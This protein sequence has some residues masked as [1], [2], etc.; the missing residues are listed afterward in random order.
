MRALLSMWKDSRMVVMVALCATMYAAAIL[1]LR[2][3]PPF[4]SQL[5]A[6]ILPIPLSL[7]FGPAA[8][9]AM[10]IGATISDVVSGYLNAGS[11]FGLGSNF[12][13]GFLPCALW[14]RLRP[15][16][17]GSREATLRSWRHYALYIVIALT[18]AWAS[19]L[20]LAWPLDRFGIAPFRF[21]I[22]LVGVQDAVLGALSISLVLLLSK[23]ITALGLS[24]W[25]VMDD[26]DLDMPRRPLGIAG[27]WL[28]VLTALIA[29][30]LAV[31][32]PAHGISIVTTGAILVFLGAA[33]M[34]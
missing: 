3:P 2:L 18:T 28:V 8:A 27:A 15:L 31:W 4:S 11:I 1:S 19:A 32:S 25:D 7:M 29:W 5:V 33:A 9:W 21:I 22:T 12:M 23:R 17:D 30:P 16:S 6:I 14:S 20:V 13:L 26:A 24:W 10:P 34:W